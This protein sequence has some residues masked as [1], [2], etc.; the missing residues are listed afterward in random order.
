MLSGE[1]DSTPVTF[2]LARIVGVLGMSLPLGAAICRDTGIRNE[3]G[4]ELR[5][6]ISVNR[7]FRTGI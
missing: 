1:A 6:C 2:C 4:E 7:Y 5:L 3:P